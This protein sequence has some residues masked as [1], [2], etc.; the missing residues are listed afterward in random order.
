MFVNIILIGVICVGFVLICKKAPRNVYS[1]SS[2]IDTNVAHY[3]YQELIIATDGFKDELGKG[4]FGIVYKG[5]LGSNAVAVKKLDR[6][7]KDGEKEFKTEVNAIGRTHHKNVVQLLG[8][9]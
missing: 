8:Y 6:V 2:T 7:L 4:S 9:C 1:S 5:I 3:T